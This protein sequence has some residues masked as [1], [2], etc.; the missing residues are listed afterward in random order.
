MTCQEALAL[1]YDVIDN[2]ASP[3]D[4]KE[5]REH[6]S[7]CKDCSEVYRV[8]QALD[9]LLKARVQNTA[10]EPAV[11]KLKSNVLSALDALDSGHTC[12]LEKKNADPTFLADNAT[13]ERE[14]KPRPAQN[15]PSKSIMVV[16]RML[17]LAASI[18]IVIGVAFYGVELFNHKDG[19]SLLEAKHLEA[20][21]QTAMFADVGITSDV[22]SRVNL[23]L[24]YAIEQSVAGYE[25]VGARFEKVEGIDVAHFLYQNG[26]KK[27]SVFVARNG[28]LSIPSDLLE[29]PVVR[30]RIEFYDHDCRGCH[31]MY[32]TVG[33]LVIVT[34]AKDRT[35]DLM[36][37]VPGHRVA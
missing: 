7:H 22:Q 23:D 8:E 28:E 32:H 36:A 13:H 17:A 20:H 12:S 2:E 21:E 37:F 24:G 31:L 29:Q 27:V 5:V 14:T 18:V 4:L 15:P 26:D 10:T 19:Y 3:V 11:D 34:A 1:L 30:D 6:L 9:N 25:M 33:D 35:I 16:G